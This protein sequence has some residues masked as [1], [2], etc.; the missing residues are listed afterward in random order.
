MTPWLYAPILDQPISSPMI[1]RTLGFCCCCAV[2]GALANV[3]PVNSA[4][5]L[6]RKLLLIGIAILQLSICHLHCRYFQTTHSKICCIVLSSIDPAV[7]INPPPRDVRMSDDRG[8]TAYAN[9]A[10]PI[11]PA[12]ADDGI[13]I[14]CEDRH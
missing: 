6:S 9:A 2:A 11:R 5:E 7:D 1:T 13:R 3:T 14:G 4:S 12:R 10:G 8:A